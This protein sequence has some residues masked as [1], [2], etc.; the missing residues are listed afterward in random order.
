V[1]FRRYILLAIMCIGLGCATTVTAQDTLRWERVTDDLQKAI[2]LQEHFPGHLAE[3][4]FVDDK[5]GFITT[6]DGGVIRTD[7][8]GLT[9]RLL[10]ESSPNFGPY[11]FFLS[12]DVWFGGGA[13]DHPEGFGRTLDAGKHWQMFEQTGKGPCYDA[14]GGRSISF[15]TADDGWAISGSSVCKTGDGGKTW[16]EVD[17]DPGKDVLQ[18]IFMLH[19]THGWIAGK[20]VILSTIDGLHWFPQLQDDSIYKAT[21]L[22]FLSEN[23]GY[24]KV[25]IREATGG[26]AL[27]DHWLTL[28]YTSNGGKTW[29]RSTWRK[30]RRDDW[31]TTNFVTQG[32]QDIWFVGGNHKDKSELFH[33]RNGGESFESVSQMPEFLSA[34]ES[35]AIVGDGK[36][37]L[38][39]LDSNGTLAHVALPADDRK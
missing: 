27:K 30:D 31:Y 20:G 21:E 12:R 17:K 2:G 3:M 14:K 24:V 5:T 4:Y 34:P 36:P 18:L 39:V 8:G 32:S 6:H 10:Y 7:D 13:L 16:S 38:L 35:I 9:W 28:L 11:Y 1:T 29:Q 26:S 23:I 25:E 15:L 19:N 22:R 37:V 33:S